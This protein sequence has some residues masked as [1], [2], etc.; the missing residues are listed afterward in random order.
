[1]DNLYAL[2]IDGAQ[3][4]EDL[5]QDYR[6]IID[7]TFEKFLGGSGVDVRFDREILKELLSVTP[8]GLDEL[9]SLRKIMELM[10]EGNYDLFVLDSAA[11]GHLLRFLE[12]PHLVR[13][14]LKTGFKLLMKYRGVVKL[15]RATELLLDLSRDIR[16]I[17]EVF[18]NPQGTEFVMITIPEEMGVA[19]MG[20]L[21]EAVA[22]LKIP[23]FHT[24]INMIIPP[25]DCG[26]CVAKSKEQQRYI[27]EIE[28][29]SPDHAIIYIPLLPHEIRGL[30]NLSELAGIM[31]GE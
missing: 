23:S 15:T 11:S 12:L 28:A 17:L 3:K 26:F 5:K 13:D 27:Q 19:E 14:W 7:A 29:K 8:P 24:I 6:D 9:M 4:L 20:D 2:E 10:K 25:T 18:S 16:K 1:M 30:E 31:F 22:K 21:E